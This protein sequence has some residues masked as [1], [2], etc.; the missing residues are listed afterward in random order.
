MIPGTFDFGT[1]AEVNSLFLQFRIDAAHHKTAVAYCNTQALESP[2]CST[3]ISL[4]FSIVFSL[5]SLGK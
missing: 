5:T 4:S 3:Q 1:P 2:Y